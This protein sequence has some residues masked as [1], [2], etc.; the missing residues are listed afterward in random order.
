MNKV[1][2]DS[3]LDHARRGRKRVE[4][5]ARRLD[6]HMTVFAATVMRMKIPAICMYLLTSVFIAGRA[7]NP[8]QQTQAAPAATPAAPSTTPPPARSTDVDSIEHIVGAVYDVISG[9][10]GAP[11]DW[12]RFR[13][14][15]YP[16]A[17]M[18]PSRRD[19]KGAVRA[20]VLTP[21]EYA[22]RAKDF[23]AKEGF[24]EGAVANR[25]ESWDHIAHVWSTYES[26][27]AAQ[28]KPFARGVNSFQLF[29]DGSRWW[30]LTVY[31][32][33]EDATHPLPEKYL[34]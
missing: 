34:K 27:H 20:F 19:D 1:V 16:G 6:W 17:H 3:H 13:S 33:G 8:T 22:T 23:F 31:W 4:V 11:R 9:P 2:R 15:Y 14:L 5:F 24:Y 25:I 18:I 29:F 28:E 21:D 30:I 7:Q 12:D 32:E 26:R 10:G